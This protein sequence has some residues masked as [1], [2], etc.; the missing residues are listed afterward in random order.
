MSEEDA[1]VVANTFKSLIRG[2]TKELAI[3]ALTE[4]F[5]DYSSAVSTVINKGA[6]APKALVPP[7]FTT[8]DQFMANHGKQK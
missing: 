4:D 2:Y 8:R 7:V 1:Q 3:A 6:A 5:F